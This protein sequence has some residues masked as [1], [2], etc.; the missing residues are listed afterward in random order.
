MDKYTLVRT[1]I[2]GRVLRLL[3]CD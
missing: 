3:N 2:I 1:G